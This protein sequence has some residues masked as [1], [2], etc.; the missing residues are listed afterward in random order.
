MSKQD[1]NGG[2]GA[3]QER[4]ASPEAMT[5]PRTDAKAAA[6]Y[7]F[8]LSTAY[9]TLGACI[10]DGAWIAQA[11]SRTTVGKKQASAWIVEQQA[12]GKNCYFKD[13][14]LGSSKDWHGKNMPT[15]AD[16]AQ[17]ICAHLDV[18]VKHYH[19]VAKDPEGFKA[20]KKTLLDNI[21]AYQPMPSEVVNTG[22]GYQARWYFDTPTTDIAA[23]EA[24]NHALAA[25]FGGD[26]QCA[27]VTHWYRLP[28]TINFPN[29]K[30]QADGRVK[31]QSDIALNLVP[32]A[33]YK[34][35][36]LPKLQAMPKVE[37][38][39]V[40]TI[41]AEE[42]D[43]MTLPKEFRRLIE[44][45]PKYLDPKGVEHTKMGAGDWSGYATSCAA[46]LRK[47]GWTDGQIVGVLTDNTLA[48]ST[49]IY[50]TIEGNGRT[51]EAQASR[52]IDWLN[53][54]AVKREV[55]P[56]DSPEYARRNPWVTETA[57]LVRPAGFVHLKHHDVMPDKEFRKAYGQCF[58]KV[59]PAQ[60]A[61]SFAHIQ[62]FDRVGYRPNGGNEF[63]ADGLRHFNLYRPC[64][65]E[66]L[67]DKMPDL[68]LN[69]L[70]YLIPDAV[71]RA[72]LIDWMAHLVKYPEH[73][74]QF[75]PLLIGPQGTGK[76]WLLD[77]LVRL[78]GR[79]NAA[80]PRNKSL[81][82]KFNSWLARKTLIGI[83]ELHG[84]E[85]VA[86]VLQDLITQTTC[87]VELKGMDVFQV[88]NFANF[89]AISNYEKPLPVTAEA[90]RYMVTRCADLPRFA[91]PK[92]HGEK[93]YTETQKMRDYYDALHAFQHPDPKVPTTDDTR[94]ALG[95]LLR[96]ADREE[97]EDYARTKFPKLNVFGV[98]PTSDA[99]D[100]LVQA[101]RSS[102]QSLVHQAH[103]GRDKPFHAEVFD[104]ATAFECFRNQAI[105]PKDRTHNAFKAAVRA[106]G[107]RPIPGARKGDSARVYHQGETRYLWA[108]TAEKAAE[109]AEWTP[110]RLS[111]LYAAYHDTLHA[112]SSS[113]QFDF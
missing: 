47:L 14:S 28:H 54:T 94:R 104:L 49:N 96:V 23:V 69:H 100:A 26:Q 77:L 12:Q 46:R 83:H 61:N 43:L 64:G 113:D 62:R 98:A 42:F 66:P 63:E 5:E 10:P 20:K 37:L 71:E 31:C 73:K 78:V 21:L 60:F 40:G 74:M 18:D 85:N 99:F 65:L 108:M 106:A 90:R 44:K 9:V 84:N 92:P 89:F 107:C 102:L 2:E 72:R 95:W 87:E 97:R 67:T 58:S 30:K 86:E 45:G 15:K 110:D 35:D 109:Y 34:L 81:G 53:E 76:S 68:L 50:K 22:N 38:K 13:C 88:E 27:D 55:W 52:V 56:E 93:P 112:A 17:L 8:H 24:C 1:N 19:D 33:R 6:D 111:E 25:A 80:A 36:A 82:N 29:K 105:D 4:H 41:E 48:V 70:R 51:A 103:R 3:Q 7:V 79:W 59:D 39:S 11:F 91:E 57:V 75:A 16:C 101:S 32:T